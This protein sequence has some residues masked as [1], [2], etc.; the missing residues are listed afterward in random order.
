MGAAGLT[1]ALVVAR[2]LAFALAMAL[3]LPVARAKRATLSI[4]CARTT[5]RQ[6]ALQKAHAAISFSLK[7]L[8]HR[9]KQR[10]YQ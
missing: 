5:S 4:D 7:R 6:A 3:G 2:A 10:F 1:L 9:A 8:F